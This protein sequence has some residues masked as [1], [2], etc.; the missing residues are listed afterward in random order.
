MVSLDIAKKFRQVRVADTNLYRGV[1]GVQLSVNDKFMQGLCRLT[2]LVEL[3]SITD[4]IVDTT[5]GNGGR[6]YGDRYLVGPRPRNNLRRVRKTYHL[7]RDLFTVV[8]FVQERRQASVETIMPVYS[9]FLTCLKIFS[10]CEICL[11]QLEL[12]RS[13]SMNSFLLSASDKRRYQ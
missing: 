1:R 9:K 11:A 10:N 3:W 13:M 2:Y 12:S 5:K 8:D 7:L 6:L 4:D